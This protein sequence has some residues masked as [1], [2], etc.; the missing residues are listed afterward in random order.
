MNGLV[1]RAVEVVAEAARAAGGADAEGAWRGAQAAPARGAS[2]AR[3]HPKGDPTGGAARAT[4]RRRLTA[5]ARGAAPADLYVRGG[6]LLNV[7]P[8]ELYLANVATRGERIAYVGA[9]DD[10]IG[11]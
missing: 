3:G 1:E 10:M 6:T 11:A 5:V 2:N 7:Y 9:R 4:C 8:G